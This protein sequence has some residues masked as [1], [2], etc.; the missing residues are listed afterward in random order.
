M[1]ITVIVLFIIICILAYVLYKYYSP[2][3]ITS[4][5]V[6]LSNANT[7]ASDKIENNNASIYY[8]DI[9]VFVNN[10]TTSD[11]PIF[12]H[13]TNKFVLSL[14]GTTLKISTGT[15]ADSFITFSNFPLQKW[16]F[17]SIVVNQDIIELYLNGK[18]VQT[19]QLSVSQ[20]TNITHVATDTITYGNADLAGYI[21]R[22]NRTPTKI[23]SEEVWAKY[24]KGNGVSVPGTNNGK[25]GMDILIN[26][27]NEQIGSYK[28]L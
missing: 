17:I 13:G 3:T 5:V 16:V 4:G 27:N 22:F 10:K 23:S 8:Y 6:S 7:I 21:T 18:L 12:S 15:T 2:S 14:D 24:L 19:K 1:D 20:K 11:K 28:I 26:Q 25:Y 9:W